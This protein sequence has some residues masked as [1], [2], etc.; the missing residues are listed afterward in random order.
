VSCPTE[1][2]W[3]LAELGDV[4]VNARDA[5]LAH[6]QGCP[7]CREANA[8]QKL[9]LRDLEAP[10]TLAVSEDEFVARV[11]ADC[12]ATETRR[13]TAST[14]RTRRLLPWATGFLA[15]AAAVTL[16]FLP[17][18]HEDAGEQVRARGGKAGAPVQ[19][20]VASA[21]VYLARGATLQR[22]GD[23]TLSTGDRLAVRVMN[24][25][26]EKHYFMAFVIDAAGDVHWLFP[27]YDDAAKNPEAPELPA[28]QEA[29]VL[30]ETVEL[31]APAEGKLRVV[32][33]LTDRRMNVKEV[34]ARLLSL[35]SAP[36]A[37]VFPESNLREW[38][39]T[40]RKH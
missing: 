14:T 8:R 24:K 36:L 29:R 11:M 9:L 40:W 25:T 35:P 2:A 13:S 5:M 39:C 16:A 15:A 21:D 26:P 17:A 4:T 1:E 10:P 22:L 28:Q 19:V 34:E 30:P 3:L 31:V 23:A 20:P 38:T 33:M 27:A 18:R 32:S 37:R 6:R 7:A 12:A